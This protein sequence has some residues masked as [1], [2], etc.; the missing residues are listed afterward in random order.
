MG[1]DNPYDDNHIPLSSNYQWKIKNRKKKPI[2]I[3]YIVNDKF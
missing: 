1:W 3:L 2:E